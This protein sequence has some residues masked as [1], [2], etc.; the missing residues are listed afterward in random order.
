ME[1]HEA[2]RI[3]RSVKTA[4]AA[5]GVKLPPSAETDGLMMLLGRTDGEKFLVPKIKHARGSAATRKRSIGYISFFRAL[6][7]YVKGIPDPATT[8]SF[9]MLNRALFGDLEDAAG[10][11]RQTEYT[12]NGS[13]HTDP[14]YINGSIKSIVT[15]MN[16]LQSSP[17]IGKEDFA[18]YLT[19]YMRELII[20]HPFEFGSP[21]TVRMFIMLFCKIKG[22]ALCYYRASPAA[23]KSAETAAFMADDVTELFRIFSDCLSYEQTTEKKRPVVK[24]RRE[25][26]R[27]NEKLEKPEA[28]ISAN[29]ET[30]N[31]EQLEKP[32]KPVRA[33][34]PARP[35]RSEKQPRKKA[36]A[37][38]EAN[39]KLK[40]AIKL[41]QKISRLNEQLTEL[42]VGTKD[43]D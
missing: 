9:S 19:H 4:L 17:I 25:L 7:A 26:D 29:D 42:M 13:A 40:R 35:E 14:K 11:T 37:Q 38:T 39:D 24:T 3:L 43:D 21:F 10:R 41:Q 8:V 20:L 33:E 32:E 1:L 30:E 28:L 2:N 31:T 6:M 16:E 18:G 36:D 15:K 27:D 5:D 22:F 12:E 34:R 23:I